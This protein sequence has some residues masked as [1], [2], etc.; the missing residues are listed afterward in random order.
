MA[1]EQSWELTSGSEAAGREIERLGWAGLLKLPRPALVAH[2]LPQGYI[3]S[4]LNGFTNWGPSVQTCVYGVTLIQ[5]TTLIQTRN[6]M[7]AF[8]PLRLPLPRWAE[9]V[10][11]QKL[12]GTVWYTLSASL[13]DN[14]CEGCSP[15][16]QLVFPLP[17]CHLF[18]SGNSLFWRNSACAFFY[19][20]VSI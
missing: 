6:L 8:S 19:F 15:Q 20:L 5:T 7:G 13:P 14:A 3:S 1:L 4:F 16:G 2:I 9:F 12:T 17:Q 11:T 18:R 10:W